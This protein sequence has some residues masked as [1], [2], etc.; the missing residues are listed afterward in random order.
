MTGKPTHISEEIEGILDKYL[1]GVQ[2]KVSPIEEVFTEAAQAIQKLIDSAVV[3]ARR[4]EEHYWVDDYSR[5]I[6]QLDGL[7]DLPEK[8]RL[9]ILRRQ[10]QDR[11]KELKNATTN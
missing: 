5:Q 10:H 1:E 6:R 4:S 11:L 7:T 8:A 3:E 9:K 2:D